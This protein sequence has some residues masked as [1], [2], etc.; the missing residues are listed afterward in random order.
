MIYRYKTSKKSSKSIWDLILF[1]LWH[2][3]ITCNGSFKG[4]MKSKAVY[5]GTNKD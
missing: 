5:K 2:D 3:Y 1:S 4:V